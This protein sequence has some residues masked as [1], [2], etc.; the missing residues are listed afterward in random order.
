[1]S[2]VGNMVGCYS[3]LGKTFVIEDEN[4]NEVTGVVTDNKVVFTAT[5]N[6]VREGSVYAS[7]I[8]VSTGTKV[9]PVYH[10]SEGYQVA[11]EGTE[12]KITGVTDYEYTKLQVLVCAFNSSASDSVATEKISVNNKVYAT[13]STIEL[14]DVTIDTENK[15]IN[16]GISNE[17]TTPLIIRYFMYKEIY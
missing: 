8:G 9:I 10:T 4:G 7:D 5:D 14:A 12:I 15:A 17:G 6:D 2:I 3:P 16:L 1:M 13:N 11:M